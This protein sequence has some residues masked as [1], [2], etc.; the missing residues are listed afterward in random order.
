MPISMT[1]RGF[2]RRY[3]IRDTRGEKGLSKSKSEGHATHCMAAHIVFTV[4]VFG[5]CNSMCK[6]RVSTYNDPAYVRIA[7]MECTLHRSTGTDSRACFSISLVHYAQGLNWL[8]R[9]DIQLRHALITCSN[10]T[11]QSRLVPVISRKLTDN[12]LLK[13]M[14]RNLILLDLLVMS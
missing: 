5:N 12:A 13:F 1:T 14:Y 9:F 6:Y 7:R 8:H 4:S 3:V 11:S 10:Q 2:K